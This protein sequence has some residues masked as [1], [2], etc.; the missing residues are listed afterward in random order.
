MSGGNGEPS[1]RTDSERRGLLPG[2]RGLI[3]F[4]SVGL[5][6]L[7]VVGVLVGF[8]SDEPEETRVE[9]RI[10][11]VRS[12]PDGNEPV[13]LDTRFYLPPG[14]SRSQQVP[15]IM[16]AHGFGGTKASTAEQAEKLAEAG[17]AVLTWTARG[18]GRSGG[19]IHLN[20]PDY[21][22]KD[23]R[24]LLDWL[25]S[26]PEVRRDASANPAVA[27]MGSS[28]G[29]ALSLLLAA[30]DDR[31]DVTVPQITWN[32][33]ERSLFPDATGNRDE[34]GVFKRGWANV[35]FSTGV[36]ADTQPARLPARGAQG[37]LAMGEKKT[38]REGRSR[39]ASNGTAA[40]DPQD[41]K[42]VV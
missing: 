11:T 2:R 18:F 28:Y 20:S 21:E 17:Y 16:L 8:V 15:A 13:D 6:L 34:T 32:D 38:A 36:A 14:A 1:G 33:L 25:A 3:L 26:R 40:E 35:L 9:D 42:S 37:P 7:A 5:A 23:A 31:V 39:G 30:Y 29:G 10:V 22:V 24:G 12:G 19:R 27:A 41:R 4:G